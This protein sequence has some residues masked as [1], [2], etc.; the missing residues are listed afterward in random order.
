MIYGSAVEEFIMM[1][2]D[3]DFWACRAKGLVVV[4]LLQT[5]FYKPLV[6][7]SSGFLSGM[8]DVRIFSGVVHFHF[9]LLG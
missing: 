6:G 4:S 1:H 3:L 9:S 8:H 7:L 2:S 5:C